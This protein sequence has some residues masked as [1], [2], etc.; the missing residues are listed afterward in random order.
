MAILLASL[1]KWL[2]TKASL[3]KEITTMRL[4]APFKNVGEF[5]SNK[6]FD[7]SFSK[8]ILL[9]LSA[10]AAREKVHANAGRKE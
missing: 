7:E 5:F 4:L 9:G 10:S 6:M 1:Q 8:N 3:T 2:N